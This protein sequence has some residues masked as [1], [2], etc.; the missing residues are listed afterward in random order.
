M[1]DL[2]SFAGVPPYDSE[3]LGVFQPLLG[4]RGRS[5]LLLQRRSLIEAITSSA[6][7][8]SVSTAA[9]GTAAAPTQLGTGN[10][11]LDALVTRVVRQWPDRSDLTTEEWRATLTPDIIQSTVQEIVARLP[12][13]DVATGVASP[14]MGGRGTLAAY[15]QGAGAA[16][17]GLIAQQPTALNSLLLPSLGATVALAPD[18]LSRFPRL[19]DVI[20]SPIGLLVL[21]RQYFFELDS[22]QGPPVGHVWLS[23][24]SS[25][26]LYESTVSR[27][28]VERTIESAL[29]V[30][31]K[32]E[33][34]TE[35]KEELS[36]SVK[37][38]NADDMKIAASASGGFNVAVA[39]GEASA[40]FDL[41][42]AR[43]TTSE[44]T[45]KRSR[46]QTEKKS[47]E[48]RQSFKTTFKT[49]SEVTDTLAM[50]STFLEISSGSTRR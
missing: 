26:E 37:Q 50:T 27:K 28:L 33:S 46:S 5:G 38:D 49:V 4:W 39:H 45:H 2:K 22:F 9:G 47:S 36:D 19:A 29:E 32:S 41:D 11:M 40:S 25:V 7:A 31:Q 16:V 3:L 10:A 21:F 42:Q 17:Q 43:K 48:I 24:G 35:T 1:A 14:A 13:V 12:Q 20:L 30:T 34:T 15:Y 18:R 6:F 8:L 23:P 44:Q